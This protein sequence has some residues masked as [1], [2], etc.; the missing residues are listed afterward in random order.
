MFLKEVSSAHPDCI[1]LLENTIL[2]NINTIQN[3]LL[4][5]NIFIAVIK[6]DLHHQLQSFS[7]SL[8]QSSVSHDPSEI[9]LI[10]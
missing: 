3:V 2:T 4:Y 1:C 7:S 6:A 8:R 5:L 10:C 9:I